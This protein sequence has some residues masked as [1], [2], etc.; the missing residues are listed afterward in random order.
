MSPT[1]V[2]HCISRRRMRAGWCRRL[3]LVTF[4]F[5]RLELPGTQARV[6]A[7]NEQ[8]WALVEPRCY[9]SWCWDPMASRG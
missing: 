6:T 1:G 8:L 2:S 4:P 7:V 5:Q 3:T 9:H